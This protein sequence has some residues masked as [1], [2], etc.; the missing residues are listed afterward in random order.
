M[1][2]IKQLSFYS[3]LLLLMACGDSSNRRTT[4][5]SPYNSPYTGGVGAGA[6]SGV[7]VMVTNSMSINVTRMQMNI[8]GTGGQSAEVYDGPA[9]F[10]GT[11]TFSQTCSNRSQYPNTNPQQPQYSGQQC[12]AAGGNIRFNCQGRIYSK[13]N[14]EC[15]ANLFGSSHIITGALGPK[16]ITAQDY[17]IIG[18]KVQGS[19]M[20]PCPF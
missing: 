12:P 3:V 16:K 10:Q 4:T 20:P 11:I 6:P 18:V 2:N 14:F 1:F 8:F 9:R 7:A 5:G 17:E 13:G 15:Q 19:C